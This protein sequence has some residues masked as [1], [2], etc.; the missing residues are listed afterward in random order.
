MASVFETIRGN[1][2]PLSNRN[3]STYL[4]GQAVSLIGTW[5]QSTAQAWVVWTLTGSEASLGVVTMLNTAPVLFLGPWAG[6]WADRLDRRKLL[7]GTQFV[8]MILA[9]ILAI[10]TQF[11]IVQLWHVYVLS[12]FLGVVTA[13]DM[14]AQQAF[15]GDLSGLGEV[16]KA[17]NLNITILQVS[18]VLGPAL[19]GMVVARLGT[20]PAFWINGISFIAVIFSLIAV[21]AN[22]D[23][24]RHEGHNESPLKQFSEGISFLRT[25]P[26]MQDMFLFATFLTF[27]VFSIIMSMLPAVADKLL[28]GDAETLGQLMSASGAGAL[29]AVLFI[30]P[31]AQARRRSGVVMI[32][33]S[34]WLVVWMFAFSLSRSVGLSMLFLFMGSMGAPTVMTMALGLIQVMSPSGMRARL[35]SLF[36][37]ISFGMQPIASL[38]I[39]F[40][41]E[42]LGVDHAIQISSVLLLVVTTLMVFLRSELT[43][44]EVTAAGKPTAALTVE[45]IKEAIHGVQ[46]IPEAEA[47]R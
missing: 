31:L 16:R 3:F 6:V 39:G 11:E 37:T 27:F 25:Q 36:T 21:R 8:A 24:S 13:L 45:G 32:L 7:I 10:L 30:V 42:R 14:P 1:F 20:A 18:R 43:T 26:R 28:G 38:W 5:L 19:A 9:F 15:L 41:A 46:P 22:Q 12:F 17:V 34:F 23:L 33:G 40:M 4:G 47:T 44:W 29:I 35:L 2:S